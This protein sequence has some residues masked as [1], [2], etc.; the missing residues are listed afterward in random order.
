MRLG[1]D[2]ELR[3]FGQFAQQFNNFLTVKRTEILKKDK[4]TRRMKRFAKLSSLFFNHLIDVINQLD[5]WSVHFQ[6]GQNEYDRSEQFIVMRIQ[7]V[8][9]A[10]F[11]KEFTINFRLAIA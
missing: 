5:I 9:V 4:F 6:C 8:N 3:L 2:E 1:R 10:L 7:T 11:V